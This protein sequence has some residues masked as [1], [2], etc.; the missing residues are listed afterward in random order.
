MVMEKDSGFVPQKLSLRTVEFKMFLR[1]CIPLA[2][3]Y[4]RVDKPL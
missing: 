1:L 4:S 3:Y 2:D